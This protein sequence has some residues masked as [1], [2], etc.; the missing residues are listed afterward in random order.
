M[1]MASA[2]E[3]GWSV[4]CHRKFLIAQW[5]NS[6]KVPLVVTKKASTLNILKS[7]KSKHQI[8]HHSLPLIAISV[9]WPDT[10]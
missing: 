6:V 8:P 2:N 1:A 5:L 7:I 4:Q 9:Q 3:Y 10:R